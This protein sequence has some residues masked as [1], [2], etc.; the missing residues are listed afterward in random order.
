MNVFAK[1]P[2]RSQSGRS[3]HKEIKIKKG[4]PVK[5]FSWLVFVIFLM[6]GAWSIAGAYDYPFK[7]PYLA[8]VIGTPSEFQPK[9]PEKIDYKM[10]SFEVFPERVVPSVF[11]YQR[12]F[13]YSLTFQKGEAPLIFVIAGTGSSFYSSNMIFF[14]KIFYQAGFHVICLPS[15][16]SMNFITTASVTSLPGNIIADAVDLYRVMTM[17]WQQ[18]KDRIK[19][20]E[21]YLTGYSL[22]ASEAAFVAKLDEEKRVFNFKKVLMINPAV[23]LYSS[24]KILD[25]ML[26]AALPGGL[27]DFDDWLNRMLGRFSE[28]FKELG[29]V[30]LGHDWLY[31]VYKIIAKTKTQ[32]LKRENLDLATMIGTAFRISSNNMI[33]TSDVM[34]NAG[35][36]VPKNLVL[37]SADSLYDYFRVASSTTF[38][39]Y[40]DD[41]LF[42][43]YKAK[44]PELTQQMAIEIDS[45]NHIEDY[46]RN[47]PKI[48]LM[49]N[50]DDLILTSGDLA[51]LKDV[52]GPRAK[53]Y[54]YGGHCGNMSYTEN[55]KHM[56]NF[57]KS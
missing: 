43:Y 2:R 5:R 53:I 39:D 12:E 8:T 44:H 18:V 1:N 27:K 54:P 24:A 41:L 46:L 29:Y 45:L 50:E 42:P 31:D 4:G 37:G 13:R 10:L 14:Q 36:I 32:S 57:F 55:V 20:S 34:T 35:L 49:G 11:W 47:S 19:V 40:F 17:A 26:L 22:G 9:L 52:F 6:G 21:F 28:V 56:L 25:K 7:D 23:S 38:V 30:D 33:F 51:F 15:P 16:T 3:R 48:G